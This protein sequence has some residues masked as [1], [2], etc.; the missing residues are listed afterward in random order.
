MS[1]NFYSDEPLLDGGI[2]HPDDDRADG[3]RW[4]Y[5]ASDD[6]AKGRGDGGAATGLTTS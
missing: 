2:P 1:N 3:H 6:E 4:D 5:V